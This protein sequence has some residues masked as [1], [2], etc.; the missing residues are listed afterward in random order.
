MGIRIVALRHAKPISEG[1]A[2]DHLRPLSEEGRFRQ[3]LLVKM[4]IEK[5]ISPSLILSSPF[6]RAVQTAEILAES[7]ELDF[8]EEPI[9]GQSYDSRKLLAMLADLNLDATV[10]LVGHAPTLENFINLL[11]GRVAIPE[12]LSKS[13][14][15]VIEFKEQ[16]V[17]GK[18]RLV[19]YLKA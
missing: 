16:I 5:E 18:G 3:R 8:A 15:A 19:H 4:L 2:E 13:S 7:F 12:G 9:L 6:L 17:L 1:Y 11:V 14:A 10:F